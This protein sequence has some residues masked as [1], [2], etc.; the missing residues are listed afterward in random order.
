MTGIR[1]AFTSLDERFER[2]RCNLFNSNDSNIVNFILSTSSL[3]V[4]V[5]LTRAVNDLSNLIIGN[6][7]GVVI[8]KYFMESDSFTEVFKIRIAASELK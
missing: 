7:S 4:V 6:K 3:Q 5:N 1:E 8:S 2:E